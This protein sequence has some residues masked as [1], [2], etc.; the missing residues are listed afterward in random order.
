VLGIAASITVKQAFHNYLD[1]NQHNPQLDSITTHVRRYMGKKRDITFGGQ[2]EH[3]IDVFGFDGDRNFDSLTMADGQQLVT[4]RRKEKNRNSTI[5]NELTTWSMAIKL[6][7]KLGHPVPKSDFRTLKRDN[8]L[9]PKKTKLRFLSREEETALLNELDPN[10][11]VN[12][13]GATPAERLKEQRRDM[14]DITVVLLDTGARYNEIAKLKWKD[15][16]LRKKTIRLWHSKTDNETS[17]GMMTRVHELL[18]RRLQNRDN[19]KEYVFTA[20]DGGPRKYSPNA[21]VNAVRRAGIEGITLH[22]LRKTF[23]SR[24][25]QNGASVQEIQQLLGHSSITT[26]MIYASLMPNQA[27]SR[28]VSILETINRGSD[29]KT[30]LRASFPRLCLTR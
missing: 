7:E 14:Y 29:A 16:D 6:N 10:T 4:A 13:I 23:A 18:T 1:A 2:E 24:L 11:V 27:A 20:E 8:Q 22:K 12:G 28:A 5:L 30:V 15:V 25:A 9:K 19:G 17:L 26:T 3:Y 21:F